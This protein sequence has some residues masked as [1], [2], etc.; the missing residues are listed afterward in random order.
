MIGVAVTSASVMS[1]EEMR[2]GEIIEAGQ[3][4][5]RELV[6][7]LAAICMLAMKIPRHTYQGESEDLRDIWV[8]DISNNTVYLATKLT[9]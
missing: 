4:G 9:G 7:L 8:E 2:S 3:D 5:N 6:L 1:L